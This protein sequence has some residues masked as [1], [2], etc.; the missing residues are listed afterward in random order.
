MTETTEQRSGSPAE[1]FADVVERVRG[2]DEPAFVRGDWAERAATL[3]GTLLPVPPPD[4]LRRPE[5]RYQMFVDEKYLAHE[6]PY[7]RSRLGE[8]RADLL[9]EDPVGDPPSL[10]NTVHHLHHLLRYEEVSGRRLADAQTIVE[11]GAGYG[12]L[13]KLIWRMHGGEPTIVLLDLPVFSA[14]QWLYLASVLGEDRVVLHADADGGG[15][16]E[17]VAGKVNVV[18]IG[19]AADLRV[20]ADLFVTTWALNESS[21]AAQDHVVGRDWFGAESLLV[22]MNDGDPFVPRVL[23]AGAT[24]WPLGPWMPGQQYYVRAG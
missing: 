13:A 6:E 12:N 5:I 18:P 23:A 14:V 11:W 20:E 7:V 19:L 17:P 3:V 15:P 24:A 21:P 9:R 1:R 10:A 22:A 8:E 2:L 16:V 4:F